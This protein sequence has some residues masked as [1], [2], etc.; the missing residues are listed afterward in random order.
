MSKPKYILEGKRTNSSNWQK[1]MEFDYQIEPTML[2]DLEPGWTIRLIKIVPRLFRK[3]KSEIV[4]TYKV[5][6]DTTTHTKKKDEDPIQN[7]VI[8][9]MTKIAESADFS[10]LK[11]NQLELPQLGGIKLSFSSG[12]NRRGA[13]VRV[14]DSEFPIDEQS[15]GGLEFEGKLPW[16]MHPVATAMISNMVKG[17]VSDVI[18]AI[19]QGSPSSAKEV[20]NKFDSVLK[21]EKPTAGGF[22]EAVDELIGEK[23]EKENEIKEVKK[24]EEAEDVIISDNNINEE[25]IEE[26]VETP[27]GEKDEIKVI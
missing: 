9:L 10:G 16:W 19:T 25:E 15:L 20:I 4:W 18:T 26:I 3:P 17:V 13:I 2:S 22:A 1:L 21:E 27:K 12:D 5:P 7:A 6:R 24:K 23:K 11:V 14:G 8:T